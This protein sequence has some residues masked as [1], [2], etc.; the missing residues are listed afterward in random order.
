MTTRRWL[1]G[2]MA[3]ALPAGITLK[4]WNEYRE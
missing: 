2:V 3:V 1:T 4:V